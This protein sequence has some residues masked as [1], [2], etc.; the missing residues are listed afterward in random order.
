MPL[1]VGDSFKKLIGIIR[2]RSCLIANI[3]SVLDWVNVVSIGC[4]RKRGTN[5]RLQSVI[6]A[7]VQRHRAAS[8]NPYLSFSLLTMCRPPLVSEFL[9][10]SRGVSL[11]PFSVFSH[12]RKKKYD[13][14][15]YIYGAALS[16][17]P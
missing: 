14:I 17:R 11:L 5:E 4:T 9:F 7:R 16:T 13:Y 12:S 6:H 3:R 2:L 1:L 10:R 8:A 15:S